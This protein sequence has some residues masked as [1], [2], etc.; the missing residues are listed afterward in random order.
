[1][2]KKIT[3]ISWNDVLQ[4][5]PKSHPNEAFCELV[6]EICNNLKIDKKDYVYHIQLGFGDKFI[7]KGQRYLFEENGYSIENNVKGID[8]NKTD[9]KNDLKYSNDTVDPLGMVL[10]NHIEVYSEN[11]LL[12]KSGSSINKYRVH[13]NSIKAGELFG[14]FGTL[15]FFFNADTE[16]ANQDWYAIAGNSCFEILFPF[17]NNTDYDKICKEFNP[18]RNLLNTQIATNI[19]E[20]V[21]FFKNYIGISNENWKTDIIYFPKHFFE[22]NNSE[23]KIKLF[24]TG[25][26]QSKASRNFLFENKILSD[27]I[28]TVDA[29]SALK[30]NKHLLNFL[31]DY[32][33][34]ASKGNVYVL[35]P[36][37][38]NEHILSIALNK[39]KEDISTY[40]SG[41]NSCTPVILH[42]DRITDKDWGCLAIDSIPILLNYPQINLNNLEADLNEIKTKGTGL[43][44][45]D[46]YTTADK[47]S[48]TD[49]YKGRNTLENSIKNILSLSSVKI[50]LTTK[51]LSNFLVINDKIK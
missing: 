7:D 13:L 34:K 15:D 10:K 18:H 26:L 49:R 41:N 21:N 31:L 8:K 24:E 44:L 5:L 2:D 25:W 4:M 28:D 30:N 1:M 22:V 48:G 37:K 9:F 29:K 42:Y 36:L 6:T 19:D 46:F 27:V 32:I 39:F 16:I 17:S 20:K 23:F 50:N 47:G 43:S 38:D 51:G 11:E 12:N 14:L 40:L 35:K 3:V 45:P 33:I